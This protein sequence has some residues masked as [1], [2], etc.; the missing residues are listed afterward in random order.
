[1]EKFTEYTCI[2]DTR[3]DTIAQK[4]YGNSFKIQEII[5]ANPNLEVLETIPAGTKV[6]VPIIE[7]APIDVIGLPPWKQNIS[8]V[9]KE[10]AIAASEILNQLV[11]SG[12]NNLG[13]FDKS[14]D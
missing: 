2:G 14:F 4:A 8:T 12:L 3:W 6:L 9:G 13:S 11:S 10:T 1:M 7:I 5:L